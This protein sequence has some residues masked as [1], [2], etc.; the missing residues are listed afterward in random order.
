MYNYNLIEY[1]FKKIT[2]DDHYKYPTSPDNNYFV[3]NLATCFNFITW[4][5]VNL[6]IIQSRGTPLVNDHFSANRFL[7]N[8][9]Y[10][11]VLTRMRA[12]FM[13]ITQLYFL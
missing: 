3:L 4:L 13:L 10:F 1:K 11:F 6:R 5:N 8:I 7:A 9:S 2:K 12:Y